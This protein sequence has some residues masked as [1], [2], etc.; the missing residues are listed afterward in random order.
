MSAC[1]ITSDSSSNIAD[2]AACNSELKSLKLNNCQITD[3]KNNF[4]TEKSA[5]DVAIFIKNN[6]ML[7]WINLG[8]N[9]LKSAGVVKIASTLK[10]LSHLIKIS[11]NNNQISEDAAISIAE[12]IASNSNL[13][14]LWLN[15]NQFNSLE[16]KRYVIHFIFRIIAFTK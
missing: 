4:I 15:N 12:V 2:I 9:K 8:D 16:S 10:D 6:S 1:P 13:K 11:L 3:I 5:E 7:K 14:E